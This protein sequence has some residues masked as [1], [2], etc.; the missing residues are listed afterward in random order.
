[1][2]WYNLFSNHLKKP[3]LKTCYVCSAQTLA[4][5]PALR[6]RD[7]QKY[8]YSYQ[9]FIKQIKPPDHL[10]NLLLNQSPELFIRLHSWIQV[11]LSSEFQLCKHFLPETK[12]CWWFPLNPRFCVYMIDDILPL[13]SVF[14]YKIRMAGTI[15]WF[16]VIHSGTSNGHEMAHAWQC[17]R[18]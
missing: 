5:K 4:H 10:Y 3:Y 9:F 15:V 11:T 1:M 12:Q 7:P 6:R 16:I 8:T 2:A 13:S 14:V 18:P 17:F